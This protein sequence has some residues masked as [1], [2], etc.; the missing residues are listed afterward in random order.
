MRMAKGSGQSARKS[1]GHQARKRF[2]QN[3]LSDMTV[4]D[5]IVRAI[6]PTPEQQ[7]IEVGPGLGAMTEPLLD[8]GAKMTAIE[9]DRDLVPVLRTKFFN[10]PNFQVIE[11]DALK[12]DFHQ[13]ITGGQLNRLVG[14]L[15]Y[16]ISTP[17]IFHLLELGPLVSDM[18][19]MLQKEVVDR[20]A[21]RPGNSSYGRLGVM[22]QYHCRVESLFN[23]EPDAFNPPPKV[24][25]AIV[26]MVPHVEKPFPCKDEKMLSQVVRQAFAMRRKT[27]R[28]CL[29]KVISAANLEAL[30]IE[31]QARPETLGVAEFVK[32]ADFACD[33]PLAAEQPG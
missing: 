20:L 11:G 32:I 17:L 24:W 5:R 6:G 15:P 12:F 21:A 1:Q 26:R 13:L 29:K 4:I 25:S 31:P 22:A 27:L 19:F 18:H 8:T 14:N 10:Y 28:N 2:G 7:V 23:V 9:L 30:G 33:H 16:N 3:F